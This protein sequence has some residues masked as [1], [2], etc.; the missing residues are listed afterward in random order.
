[1]KTKI[2]IEL[3]DLLGIIDSSMTPKYKLSL[4]LL[5]RQFIDDTTKKLFS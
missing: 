5:A 3:I 1:M 4:P 2:N